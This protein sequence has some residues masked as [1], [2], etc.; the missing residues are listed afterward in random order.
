MYR[1]RSILSRD[2]EHVSNYITLARLY[3][4]GERLLAPRFRAQCLWRFTQM[5]GSNTTIPDDSI[6]DLLQIACTD[7]VERKKEDPLRAHIFWYAGVRISGLQKSSLFRHLLRNTPEVGQ[8]VCLWVNQ[9]QPPKPATPS[10]TRY[11]RFGPESEYS[12]DVPPEDTESQASE[13]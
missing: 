1:D 11:E 9:P 12:L 2:I 4:M 5:L 13:A 7:V 10:Q 6:C 8:Q 3:A